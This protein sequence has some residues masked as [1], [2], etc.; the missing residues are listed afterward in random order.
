MF[1]WLEFMANVAEK[2]IHGSYVYFIFSFYS[3][4]LLSLKLKLAA[5][6]GSKMNISFPG[7]RPIFSGEVLVERRALLSWICLK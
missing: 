7:K 4:F 6:H 1:I 2:A 3:F 5:E